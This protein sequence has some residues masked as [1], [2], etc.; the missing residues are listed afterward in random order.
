MMHQQ[1]FSLSIMDMI[2]PVLGG[3]LKWIYY[4]GLDKMEN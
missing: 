3:I 4:Y 1:I 2:A